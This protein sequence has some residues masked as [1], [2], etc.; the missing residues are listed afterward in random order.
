MTGNSYTPYPNSVPGPDDVVRREFANGMVVLVR[1]NH[2]SPAVVVAGYLPVGAIDVPAEQAGLAAFAA[3]ALMRGTEKRDFAQIYEEIESVGAQASFGSGGHNT[4]FSAK[5]LSEDLG[6]IVEILADAMRRPA[7]PEE[8]IERL[9]GQILTGLAVRA[10]DTGARAGLAFREL[11][12]PQGHPYACSVRGYPETVGTLTRDDLQRFYVS[13]YG[14]QGLTI[15]IVGAVKAQDAL[16]QVEEAFG[17]WQGH[18]SLREPLASV[19]RPD[20]I[21]RKFVEMPGKSQTD[22]VMGSPGPARAEPDYLDIAVANHIL[23]VFGMMGRL[24]QHLRDE[25]GLAYSIYS[26]LEDGHGPG[27]WII[28]AGVDPANVERTI[29]AARDEVRHMRDTLVEPAE[30]ADV[31]TYLSGSL[32]LSLETNE[33]VAGAILNIEQHQL[34]LDYLSRYPTLIHRIT[35]ERILAA[36]RKWFD[37]ENLAI[38]IAG[39]RTAQA[40]TET[41]TR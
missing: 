38:G 8:E 1:E 14:A 20:G 12:Y 6:L 10:N 39:P 7:F 5:S 26:R 34:G 16:A 30:L 36:A 18:N 4:H 21:V 2:T 15:C 13:G 27:P 40:G 31:Q 33:G 23:G 24:G 32:P 17:D 22:I 41:T 9:R 3:S 29:A 28:A 25:Q 11:A 35:R 19:D 37:V